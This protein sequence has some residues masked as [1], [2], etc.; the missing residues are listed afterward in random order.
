[1]TFPCGHINTKK[2]PANTNYFI[3]FL[4][5]WK[6]SPR[7][8]KDILPIKKSQITFRKESAYGIHL[9]KLEFQ[10]VLITKQEQ[11]T[12]I[13]LKSCSLYNFAKS[14]VSHCFLDACSRMS[15]C[16]EVG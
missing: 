1:M 15:S 9:K 14:K 4:D 2:E 5:L 12:E 10:Q 8:T 7:F 13:S 6:E 3:L 11:F 16:T